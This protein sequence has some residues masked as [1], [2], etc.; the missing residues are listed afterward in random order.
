MDDSLI[1]ELFRKQDTSAIKE[2]ESKYGKLLFKLAM[3]ILCSEGDAEETVNDT[4]LTAWNNIRISPPD[5]LMSYLCKIARNTALKKYRYGNAKKRSS[6]YTLSLD[7]IGDIFSSAE[8][9]EDIFMSKE[10][11]NSINVFIK[12]L[13]D[14]DRRIFMRR[15][16]YFDSLKDIS[17]FFGMNENNVKSSLFRS[18]Q[19]LK[20]YLQKEGYSL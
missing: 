8:T 7:E 13:P 5:N 18:R 19:K 2:A 9:P 1:I 17:R 15:Y 10:L 12:S 16:W 11:K 14:T 3:G 4:F 6:E 20:K